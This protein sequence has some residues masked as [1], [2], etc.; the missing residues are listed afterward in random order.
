[1]ATKLYFHDTAN[2]QSG[3]YPASLLADGASLGWTDGSFAG[4]KKMDTTINSGASAHAQFV[5][6]TLSST[7][8]QRKT[9]E[10]YWT[11]PPLNGAQTVG[12]GNMVLN[13]ADNESALTANWWINECHVLVWRPSTGAVVGHVR[14]F[15]GALNGLGGSEASSASSTQVTHIATISTSAVSAADGDVILAMPGSTHQQSMAAVNNVMICYDGAVENTTENA[16]V[17]NQASYIQFNE[18]LSFQGGAAPFSPVAPFGIAGF[19][20]I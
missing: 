13:V 6:A 9:M 4:I 3:T 16:A 19:F 14:N 1:M 10:Y 2:N 12:G 11:S 5:K 18:N 7:S 8:L 17:S 15:V 20:G